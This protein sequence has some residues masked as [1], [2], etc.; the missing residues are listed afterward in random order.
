MLRRMTGEGRP[1]PGQGLR[2][3]RR[4]Q[5]IVGLALLLRVAYWALASRHY[6]PQ[7]DASQYVELARNLAHGHGYSATFP[8]FDRHPAAFRPPLYPALLSVTFLLSGSAI[9]AGMALNLAI[10]LAVVVV[11]Y[12]L[13]SRLHSP[14]AGTVAAGLAAVYPPLLVNDVRLLSEPIS[15]LLLLGII[16]YLH[17][18]N[19]VPAGLCAGALVLARPSAQGLALIVAGWCLWQLGWKR[20]LRVGAVAAL[21]VLPWVVRNWV[22]LG[23]PLLVTSN[24]FNLVAVYSAE[25]QHDGRFVD[26][27]KDVR[28]TRLRLA[29][30]DEADWDRQ[31]QRLGLHDLRRHPTY[32]ATVVARNARSFF[33]LA[34]GKNTWPERL[35]GRAPTL[36]SA[37]IPLFVLVTVGGFVGL[38]LGRRRPPLVLLT[39]VAGY[40]TVTSLV[41]IA[42]PRLRAPLDLACCIGTG[43]LVAEVAARRAARTTEP[44]ARPTASA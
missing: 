14:L 13:V 26:E 36:Q 43:V 38:W 20:T 10:G 23:R 27:T 39:L 32:L 18:R 15:L 3:D 44:M 4:L 16:T 40:F 33:E 21:V 28:F 2:H 5:A 30:F 35:D 9:A 29:Q 19:L 8:Q 6:V 31:L 1:R 34:P 41:L 37:T 42:A 17:D 12:R 22:Q 24:G 7:S 11:T 25:A